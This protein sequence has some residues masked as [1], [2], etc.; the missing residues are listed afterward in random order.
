[1]RIIIVC[2]C[3]WVVGW[4]VVVELLMRVSPLLYELQIPEGEEH[5]VT[6]LK[7]RRKIEWLVVFSRINTL[8]LRNMMFYE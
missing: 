5:P 4:S 3:C 6:R 2:Y 7:Q 8:I 1:M